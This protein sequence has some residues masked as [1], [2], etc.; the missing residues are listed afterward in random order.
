VMGFVDWTRVQPP[1]LFD[2]RWRTVD[3]VRAPHETRKPVSKNEAEGL[4]W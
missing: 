4:E 3:R 2:E 1:S